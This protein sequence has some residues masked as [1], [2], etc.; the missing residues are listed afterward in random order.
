MYRSHALAESDASRVRE[1]AR[2]LGLALLSSL[3]PGELDKREARRLTDELT[4]LRA[5]AALLELDDEL[6]ALAAVANWCARTGGRAWLQV[7]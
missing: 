6:T 7:S 2:A 1:A 4:R 5:S 3:A